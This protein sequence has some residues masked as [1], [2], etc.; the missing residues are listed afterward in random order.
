[1]LFTSFTQLSAQTKIEKERLKYGNEAFDK[2]NYL[3]ALS[4]FQ[5]L[6]SINNS[7][8]DYNFKY[9]ACLVYKKD[10]KTAYKHLN[11]AVENNVADKRV[12]FFLGKL[13]HLSYSFNSAI[14]YYNEFKS[15]ADAKLLK[16]YEVENE[17]QKCRE[18]KTLLRNYSELKVYSKKR[19]NKADFYRSYDVARIGGR[20]IISDEFQS[21]EDKKRDHH[22][23]I[24]LSTN[25]QFIFYSSYG[26]NGENGL[27]IYMRT[28]LPDGKFSDEVLLP[29]TINTP[30]DDNYAYLGADGKTLYFSSKGHKG[31]GGY[32]IFKVNYEPGSGTSGEPVNLDFKINS[33]DD[34]MFYITDGT[35][36]KAYFASSRETDVNHVNVYDIGVTS[37]A[38]KNVLIAG[39]IT[40]NLQ[41][42]DTEL[43]IEALD[44]DAS[45]DIDKAY[46]K[47]NDSQFLL[48]LPKGG[49]Y[50]FKVSSKK[51]RQSV[52][53]TVDVPFSNDLKPLKLVVDYQFQNDE[54]KITIIKRFSEGVSN[55]DEILASY[56]RKVSS[57][58][59]NPDFDPEAN[60]EQYDKSFVNKKLSDLISQKEKEQLRLK[61]Q[62]NFAKENAADQLE[63]AQKNQELA[64]EAIN[65]GDY[66]QAQKYQ[67]KADN[68][69]KNSK[70]YANNVT[71]IQE[72][73]SQNEKVLTKSQDYASQVEGSN[74]DK[75]KEITTFV[76]DNQQDNIIASVFQKG[77]NESKEE[78]SDLK[79]DV[80]VLTSA[81]TENKSKKKN[82]EKELENTSKRKQKEAIQQQ[83]DVVNQELTS[84]ESQRE[85]KQNELN[86]KQEEV[87]QYA[88]D[89][90]IAGQVSSNKEAPSSNVEIADV[91][92]GLNEYKQNANLISNEIAQNT[93]GNTNTNENNTNN[94][95]NTNSESDTNDVASNNQNNT[96]TQE[97]RIQDSLQQIEK[98]RQDSIKAIEEAR[99]DS[100]QKIEAKREQIELKVKELVAQKEKELKKSQQQSGYTYNLTDK[101]YDSLQ[102]VEKKIAKESDPNKLAELEK[103]KKRLSI[104]ALNYAKL[105]KEYQDQIATQNDNLATGQQLTNSNVNEQNQDD[106]L[107]FIEN[108][109]T[110]LTLSEFID[111][112]VDDKQTDLD[113]VKKQLDAVNSRVNAANNKLDELNVKLN[114]ENLTS[115]QKQDVVREITQA[116]REVEEISLKQKAL[117]NQSNVIQNEILGLY[118]QQDLVDYMESNSTNKEITKA[119]SDPNKVNTLVA[120]IDKNVSKE[121]TT[122]PEEN[123]A[124]GEFDMNSE[125]AFLTKMDWVQSSYENLVDELDDLGEE[126]DNTPKTDRKYAE[127]KNKTWIKQNN[128][129]E[130]NF[131]NQ[132]KMFESKTKV[133]TDGIENTEDI[134]KEFNKSK[135]LAQQ[136]FNEAKNEKRLDKKNELYKKAFTQLNLQKS[137]LDELYD[138]AVY[139][140]YGLYV[141]KSKEDLKKDVKILEKEHSGLVDEVFDLTKRIEN[142]KDQSKRNELIEIKIKKEILARN[143]KKLIDDIKKL[144]DDKEY[145]EQFSAEAQDQKEKDYV[146]AKKERDELLF[147]YINNNEWSNPED[148]DRIKAQYE[149]VVTI[150]K[151][152]DDLYRQKRSITDTNEQKQVQEKIDGLTEKLYNKENILFSNILR[153]TSDN[154][155]NKNKEIGN[156]LNGYNPSND[157]ANR[158]TALQKLI[159]DKVNKIDSLRN[160]QTDD[161]FELAKNKREIAKL[162]NEILKNQEEVINLIDNNPSV[163]NGTASNGG[164]DEVFETNLAILVDEEG[165]ADYDVNDPVSSEKLNIISQLNEDDPEYAAFL[166]EVNIL[167]DKLNAA[168]KG[169]EE[170]KQLKLQLVELENAFL[171]DKFYERF[172]SFS[173][174]STFSP[175]AK[176][177]FPKDKTEMIKHEAEEMFLDAKNANDLAIK[178]NILKQA[179]VY[180]AKYEVQVDSI[181]EANAQARRDEYAKQS[182][183]AIDGKIGN[184]QQDIF[185]LMNEV[186]ALL[187]K[188]NKETDPYKKQQLLREKERK[189]AEL[190]IKRI[191]IKELNNIL[192]E[193]NGVATNNENNGNQTNQNNTN[194]NNNKGDEEKIRKQID[195]IQTKTEQQI[196]EL[197]DIQSEL[198]NANNEQQE[199]L[200]KIGK[201]EDPDEK[202][203]LYDQYQDLKALIAELQ[204][205]LDAIKKDMQASSDQLTALQGKLQNIQSGGPSTTILIPTGA[206]NDPASFTSVNYVNQFK[207]ANGK[208][209]NSNSDKYIPGL[210]YK[211]QIGAFFNPV[212]EENFKEFTPITYLK[213]P[214][215]KYVRY[216]AGKFSQFGVANDA[217]NI[218]R[219]QKGYSDAFVVAFYNGQK[220]SVTKARQ[221]EQGNE[222]VL[223]EMKTLTANATQ[224]GIITTNNGNNSNNVTNQNGTV[225][226]GGNTNNGNNGNNTSQVSNPLPNSLFFTVQIGALRTNSPGNLFNGITDVYSTPPFNGFIRFNS[227][228]FKS[229]A[230]A[231]QRLQ[232]VRANIQ[233]AFIVAYYQGNRISLAEAQRLIN[234]FGEDII[235]K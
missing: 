214:D 44:A 164:A 217:K 92:A 137:Q 195:E 206:S 60:E 174:K 108:Q 32:D 147:D 81:I 178:N 211:V 203:A 38:L 169:S 138:K 47:N 165:V 212:S 5:Y 1:M 149:E 107:L 59:V 101:V 20:V 75:L 122:N 76:N 162:Q 62:A 227:G 8:P 63:E 117:Y 159:Q 189:E 183:N 93:T 29:S 226:N 141:D 168:Q 205:K 16:E 139:N 207:T 230:T 43:K 233:D 215:S 118:D 133:A 65:N 78:L 148:A 150:S 112:K 90:L 74:D 153:G 120:E 190:N 25:Q 45:S 127:L 109:Q 52:E 170:Y 6:V 58:E 208:T 40:G 70:S 182:T 35:G 218:I 79:K 220:I 105:L 209:T 167:L 9:G 50:T 166:K 12:Y 130:D 202:K 224:S 134:E 157:V 51:T 11:Y 27:D 175:V 126:M 185:N 102:D 145:A 198:E 204:A 104:K 223:A 68:A 96:N 2:G 88:N 19:V 100:V 146:A 86:S 53:A 54:E 219:G 56:Y 17:I 87:D 49:K 163:E 225:N 69:Y 116:S 222:E 89:V 231:A 85:A 24:Y 94:T 84:L 196:A 121:Y 179:F 28:K 4:H 201:T 142:E 61:G 14:S 103:E 172:E 213:I 232:E 111:K 33:P 140:E 184:L 186:N 161:K 73:V 124:I 31:L 77:F 193:R 10:L 155:A 152:I 13:S 229:R 80:E 41:E 97:N 15:S 200:D 188:Y 113:N 42:I 72:I 26:R 39:E 128:F 154:I 66:E 55:Q 187:E 221:L 173:A 37:Y 160:V 64:Q 191:Q 67:L 176:N 7:E 228:K 119:E 192:D 71:K 114:Q 216:Y 123:L 83:L 46:I 197:K 234:Q 18:A 199:L 125:I 129:F 115:E 143:K 91:V 23:V 136:Y 132:L 181:E 171:T 82:L 131:E 156:K 30:Y 57:P 177:A 144:I 194:T 135:A 110:A 235:I 210:V 99:Q 22:P 21:K 48:T 158:L 95:N 98:A 36:E 151:Q 34:D 3:E 180:I 106:Y